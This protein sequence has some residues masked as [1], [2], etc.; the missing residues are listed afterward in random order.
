MLQNMFDSSTFIGLVDVISLVER[1]EA[2]MEYL[3]YYVQTRGMRLEYLPGWLCHRITHLVER[4]F[5]G[6]ETAVFHITPSVRVVKTVYTNKYTG[7]ELYIRDEGNWV[8]VK[9]F[10]KLYDIVRGNFQQV[11]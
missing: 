2:D 4:A 11:C 10:I 6:K 9:D 5:E 1:N 3:L 8:L 7:N